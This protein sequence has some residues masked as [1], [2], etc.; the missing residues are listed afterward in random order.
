M[1]LFNEFW[2]IVSAAW[3]QIAR[4]FTCLL[5]TVRLRIVEE[6]IDGARRYIEAVNEKSTSLTRSIARYLEDQLPIW[7]GERESLEAEIEIN[8]CKEE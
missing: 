1:N 4:S 6:K 5:L 2:K 7:L 3:A 8:G